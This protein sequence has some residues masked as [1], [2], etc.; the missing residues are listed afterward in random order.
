MTFSD[1]VEVNFDGIVGPT[2]NYSGLSYGNVAS[3]RNQFSIS[4]PREAALQG[5]EKMKFLAGLGIEQAILLPHER[6]HIP[7][8]RKLGFSGM[9]NK[10]LERASQ[11]AP[12]LLTAACSAAAMWTANAATSS[13]STD[14]ADGRLHLTAANL[15][16]K[17]HRAIEQS[18]TKRMLEKIFADPKYFA[19]HDALFPGSFF[20]D[21]GAA[22][23]T[24]LCGTY[25]QPG[26]H[27]FVFGR[28]AFK[29]NV[30]TPKVYP[31]R[32]TCEA[33]QAIARLH[34]LDQKAIV[35]AQQHPDAIDAGAF[36]NDV[37]AVGNGNVLFFHEMAF[38]EKEKVK[39]DLKH[40]VAAHCRCDLNLI[41]VKN[42]DIPIEEAINT[43]LFNSQLVSLPQGGMALIAPIECREHVNVRQYLETM[44]VGRDSP[45]VQVHYL[46]LR[47]SMRNGGGPACL[48]LRLVLSKAERSASLPGV[49]FTDALYVKLR[50]WV[51]RHYRDSL[52]PNELG[53]PSLLVEVREALDELTQLLGTGPLYDFQA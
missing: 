45:I 51:N 5:L 16:S 29:H 28:Y 38:V 18:F 23:H 37:V 15:S 4:N 31:A 9:D 50:D 2:H 21:E 3:Q 27:F 46:N 30:W 42:K 33:S 26:I 12:E 44:I 19:H 11:E 39:D 43:Y 8:L 49:Y 6:P 7:T 22:N 1:A 52:H 35:F 17:F 32:Q 48:R 25:G 47:Q 13:P 10:V 14:T 34:G 36:H 41:E 40:K 24:R 20:A 53:D